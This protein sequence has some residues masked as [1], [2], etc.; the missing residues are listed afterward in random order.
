MNLPPSSTPHDQK[1][2]LSR[3]QEDDRDPFGGTKGRRE[4]KEE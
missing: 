2:T 4:E 3:L 1:K